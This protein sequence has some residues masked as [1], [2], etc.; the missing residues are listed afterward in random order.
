MQQSHYGNIVVLILGSKIFRNIDCGTRRRR[1]GGKAND[2][3]KKIKTDTEKLQK[4]K[5]TCISYGSV[6]VPSMRIQKRRSKHEYNILFR[7]TDTTT[8]QL[9]NEI[10]F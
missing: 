5:N 3:K 1:K 10:I 8:N 2:R 7:D 9:S 4:K 6:R